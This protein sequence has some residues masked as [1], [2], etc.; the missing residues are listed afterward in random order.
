MS[1]LLTIVEKMVMMDN[2][3][4]PDQ[5]GSPEPEPETEPLEEPES[6]D[7]ESSCF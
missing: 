4:T 7:D 2:L 1:F 6:V 3:P 5:G